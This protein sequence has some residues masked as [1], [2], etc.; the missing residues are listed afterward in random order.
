MTRTTNL[1]KLAAA[2]L[3]L[4]A[5]AWS[6]SP[7]TITIGAEADRQPIPPD[8]IGLSFETSNLLP[9]K[10]GKYLFTPENKPL[11]KLFQTI[12]IKNI[13]V[14]GGTADDP[15]YPDPKPADID[16]LFAFARAAGVD[17]I[18]TVRLLNGNKTNAAA[19]V[20]YIE[21]H[22]ANQVTAFQV[23]NEPDWHSYHT[24]PEHQR[25]PKIFETTPDISGTAYPS[26]IADWND[27]AA[28]ISHAAPHATFTGPDTGSNYP[29]PK[30]T[31]DTDYDGKS[32][33]QQFADS[34]KGLRP[35]SFVT[36]HDYVGE[37]ATGVSIPEAVNAMLSRQWISTNYRLLFDH[38]LSP[39]QAGGITY[40]MTECNDYT[41]G[42]DGASNAYASAL[43]GLDYMHWHALHHAAGVNF[44]NK[45]W[46]FTDTIFLDRDGA[47]RI[48]PK[49]YGL[50]AFALGSHGAAQPLT[51]ANSEDIN[52]TAYA[53]RD[54]RMLFITIINKEHGTGARAAR[55]TLVAQPVSA[56]AEVMY[57]SAPNGDVTA[58]RGITLGG[59]A[60]DDGVW[61]GK[62]TPLPMETGKK[63]EVQVPAASAAIVRISLK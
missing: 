41:G 45:R 63:I 51:I 46:I 60:I 13:R 62:W 15:N 37:G 24:A 39:V 40:R 44:H 17:V 56:T 58:R 57:L 50:K 33:T 21:N 38:V 59:A 34:E 4:T 48:N 14:G 2:V 35:I 26:F 12:G 52:L 19:T 3:L 28:A 10:T 36:Q 23:G 55:T 43:W 11:I 6:Q 30:A 18:Y 61:D 27:F 31:K 1:L 47:F 16:R 8:F 9:D 54:K 53:V 22:Y 29:V 7:V 49:A 5:T 32:W 25:D 42:V 20:S